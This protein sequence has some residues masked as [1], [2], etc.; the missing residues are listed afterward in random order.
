MTMLRCQTIQC[1]MTPEDQHRTVG[2]KTFEVE[3]RDTRAT[4]RRQGRQVHTHTRQGLR[5]QPAVMARFATSVTGSVRVES[6]SG[7][8][9]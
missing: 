4:P 6:Q 7:Q 8:R 9:S 1:T 3:D 2:D 5:Q